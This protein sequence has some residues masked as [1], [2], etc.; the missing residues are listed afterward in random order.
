MTRPHPDRSAVTHTVLRTG[1]ASTR[2]VHIT[3]GTTDVRQRMLLMARS[4]TGAPRQPMARITLGLAVKC[5]ARL[6]GLPCSLFDSDGR[7]P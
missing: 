4:R 7:R 3:L 5:H 1:R 6:P 2:E